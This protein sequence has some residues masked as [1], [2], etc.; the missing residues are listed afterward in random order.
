MQK[1]YFNSFIGRYCKKINQI[2]LE[3]L[4]VKKYNKLST[5]V[6][7]SMSLVVLVNLINFIEKV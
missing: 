6:D 3:I 2:K 1:Q 5:D 7:F 4:I